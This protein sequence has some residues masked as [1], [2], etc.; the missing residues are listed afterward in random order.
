[1]EKVGTHGMGNTTTVTNN[2][3]QN[4]IINN[5]GHEDLSFIPSS[6]LS[7]L[8]RIPYGGIPKLLRNIHFNPN[9]PQNHNLRIENKKRPYISVFK[10]NKW[11]MF[12]KWN[13]IHGLIDSGYN[14]LGDHYKHDK[15]QLTNIHNKRFLKFQEDYD[16]NK[17]PKML[18]KEVELTILNGMKELQKQHQEQR[19]IKNGTPSI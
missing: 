18:E 9:F 8:I 3:T 11:S 17:L 13:I 19:L 4:I 12:Q 10:N 7:Y 6:F 2:N 14:I 5:Y 16:N 15:D 1:M